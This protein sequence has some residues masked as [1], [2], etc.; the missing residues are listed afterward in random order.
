[1]TC[2]AL[3]VEFHMGSLPGGMRM[4]LFIRCDDVMRTVINQTNPCD[5]LKRIVSGAL[6]CQLV[7]PALFE[8]M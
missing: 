4:F 6:Y 8:L 5:M 2:S 3:T 7:C 1:M